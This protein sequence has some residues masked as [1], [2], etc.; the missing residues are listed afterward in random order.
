MVR[1]RF[2]PSPTGYL[3]IGGLRTALYNKL[4]ALRH[5]GQIFLRIEDTDQSRLVPGAVENLIRSLKWAG[6]EFAEGP[7]L[8]DDGQLVERGEF[9][10]YTQSARLDLYRRHAAE[11]VAKGAAYPCFCSVERLT[12][13]RHTQELMKQPAGYDRHCRA[14]ESAEA[15]ARAA[16]EPHVIRFRMPTEGTTEAE[17]LIRGHVSFENALLDDFVIMKTDGYPTYHLA[18][19]IDDHLMQTTHVIRGEEWLPSIPK[20][21][22]LFAAFGW[23]A[24]A[25]AHLPLL[26][27]ADRSKLSKRQGDVAV[28]DYRDKGYLPE[29]LI[30]FVA[31]MGWNPTGDREIYSLEELG[32]LFDIA[33]VNKGGA[34]LNVEK[35][36]WI[37]KEYLKALPGER[38]VALTLPFLKRANLV[39]EKH[40][41]LVRLDS[42]E[43]MSRDYLA[44]ALSLEQTRVTVLS[45]LPEAI[46]Y[47]LE[48]E[49]P[50]EAALIPWRKSTPAEAKE[51]L[52]AMAQFLRDLPAEAFDSTTTIEAPT[53]AFIKEHGWG[54]GDTLWPTRVALSGRTASPSPFEII[55]VLGR[56]ESVRRLE[57]AHNLLA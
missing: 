51:R 21:L 53:M 44:K 13:L 46:R 28:E 2:S 42:H 5:G 23:K 43:A 37:N 25:Y 55:W 29:A 12:E 50:L 11:L 36:N 32:T 27:N 14:L 31:T 16:A 47:L 6:L 52:A 1:V 22:A 4:F 38:L 10:P 56:E 54:N 49:Y 30:N 26:L 33:N 48:G 17:D 8:T 19:A 35:L 41:T 20:H 3:H 45:E 40:G 7:A 24:P 39:E 9:G 57:R 15:A 18:H 34:V